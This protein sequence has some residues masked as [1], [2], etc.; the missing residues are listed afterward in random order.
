MTIELKNTVGFLSSL[1]VS[2][3]ISSALAA[4][5]DLD[6]PTQR[7]IPLP[8]TRPATP[9]AQTELMQMLQ[10]LAQSRET[11]SEN[12]FETPSAPKI[13]PEQLKRLEKIVQDWQKKFP[14]M[15]FQDVPKIPNELLQQ[16]VSDPE[17]R[18]QAKQ[19]LEAFAKSRS[20]PP[21][22]D[23]S[24]A[25][26]T[27]SPQVPFPRVPDD[28]ANHTERSPSSNGSSSSL[29]S[30]SEK[31]SP[32]S[33]SSARPSL[34]QPLT[35]KQGK[36]SSDPFNQQKTIPSNDPFRTDPSSEPGTDV[37]PPTDSPK[38]PSTP[39]NTLDSNTNDPF[40]SQSGKQK[41][42]E[43]KLRALKEL[44]QKLESIPPL[45][46]DS[47]SAPRS[48]S[49]RTT[50]PSS[51][52]TNP[53]APSPSRLHD[54][55]RSASRSS[56][57]SSTLP[58][59]TPLPPSQANHN[60]PS[61]PSPLDS[62]SLSHNDRTL[63][64]NLSSLSSQHE[65]SSDS[66]SNNDANSN[67]ESATSSSTRSSND[68]SRKNSTS[69]ETGGRNLDADLDRI[70]NRLEE[71]LKEWDKLTQ[72]ADAN[73]PTTK[74]RTGTSNRDRTSSKSSSPTTNP[75]TQ[76]DI[77]S[78]VERHGL[79]GAL[80]RIVE[81]T[82]QEES[83]R[84]KKNTEAVSKNKKVDASKDKAESSN[85][86]P[87]DAMSKDSRGKRDSLN[88]PPEPPKPPAHSSLDSMS[89]QPRSPSSSNPSPS[90]P[91]PKW[92]QDL[93]A[94]ISEVPRTPTPN[95]SS[96]SSSSAGGLSSLQIRWTWTQTL[97]LLTAC[98]VGLAL[99]Y[100]ARRRLHTV[101]QQT[102]NQTF[103][104]PSQRVQDIQSREDVV[105]AFH[106]LV[107]HAPSRIELWLPHR[108]A[109]QH[110]CLSHPQL[111]EPLSQL[112]EAYEHCRYLPPDQDMPLERLQEIRMAYL[113]CNALAP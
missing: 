20:F 11:E 19:L 65:E 83:N 69:K 14:D 31:N 35:D 57:N 104:Q 92:V 46:N 25:N 1:I 10:Q 40:Q 95:G 93:W 56:R 38:N 101:I 99:M 100:F 43:Q 88:P 48:S 76:L 106:T 68:D 44:F 111:E 109:A 58:K 89:I 27:R 64:Q 32:A 42:D 79:G 47:R 87:W 4:Q 2:L 23:N 21:L 81:K 71:G 24:D 107:Q 45:T 39:A 105:K 77:K 102:W 63:P 73:S 78:E 16:V 22:S 96:A 6:R 49:P 113:Q 8:N 72:P 28:G 12:P 26:R 60:S 97:I 70:K 62:N 41:L 7:W 86:I 75:S 55:T 59:P 5:D 80:Q 103:G 90:H 30:S 94:S 18:E 91:T 82:L 74:P 50:S 13:D 29:R 37:A 66:S 33:S 3:S 110:L 54:P 84:S 112:A 17:K 51:G 15:G 108:K 98:G 85:L 9:S 61:R 53:S 52:S 34:D 67:A 36:D